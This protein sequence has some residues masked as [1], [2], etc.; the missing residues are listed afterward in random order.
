MILAILL[1]GL[2]LGFVIAE[3]FFPSLGVLSV[4][5]GACVIGSLV[6][7]FSESPA[8]GVRFSIATAVL[9]PSVILIGLRLFPK[10]P[11]GKHMTNPGLSFESRPATDRRDL[12]LVGAEGVVDSECRPAGYAR[13][14]GRRV[15]VVSRG[16]SIPAGTRVVVSEV[17]GNRVV[18]AR[19]PDPAPGDP[20]GG[21]PPATT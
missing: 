11:M 8:V 21:S 12:D 3:V 16:E 1:L 15:D 13:I 20:S 6:A 7:A 14:G 4:L 19:A 9:L 10:S 2:G 17:R 18:V 5:A